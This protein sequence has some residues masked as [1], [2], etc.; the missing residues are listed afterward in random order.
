[1]VV[2]K[3]KRGESE[4][5]LIARFRKVVLEEGIMDEVRERG[6]HKKPSEKKK[7]KKAL[8]KFKIELEKKRNK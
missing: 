7:E 3:K 2:V 8:V 1:M 6:R 4:D 5:K